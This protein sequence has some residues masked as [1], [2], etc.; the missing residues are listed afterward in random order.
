MTVRLL[1]T[2][3]HW[4]YLFFLCVINQIK[5]QDLR[6]L[7]QVVIDFFWLIIEYAAIAWHHEVQ[8]QLTIKGY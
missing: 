6:G 4:E 8:N 3:V 2:V 7:T 1:T 5:I